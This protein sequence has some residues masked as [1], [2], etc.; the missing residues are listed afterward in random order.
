VITDQDLE[1]YLDTLEGELTPDTVLARIFMP[2]GQYESTWLSG[3]IRAIGSIEAMM[4]VLRRRKIEPSGSG[5]AWLMADFLFSNDSYLI[6][7][8]AEKMGMLKPDWPLALRLHLERVAEGDGGYGPEED[9]SLLVLGHVHT[10]EWTAAL[11]GVR[12]D[13]R[14]P[15]VV[16]AILQELSLL[17]DCSLLREYLFRQH[18]QLREG[19]ESM[20]AAGTQVHIGQN[21]HTLEELVPTVKKVMEK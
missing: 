10:W 19:A 8:V 5:K 4:R 15:L 18:P 3:A 13:Y 2:D 9:Y 14:D 7:A 17:D 1:E 6:L 11:G 12:L 21:V 16:A 20:L